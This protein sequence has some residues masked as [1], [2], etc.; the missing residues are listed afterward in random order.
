MYNNE[1]RNAGTV[2]ILAN[3][4]NRK[5][6]YSE[7]QLACCKFQNKTEDHVNINLIT[8]PKQNN[9]STVHHKG[10]VKEAFSHQRN[11]R[12]HCRPNISGPVVLPTSVRRSAS[13]RS[14]PSREVASSCRS[15]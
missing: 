10:A 8:Q 9:E 4:K 7:P 11:R 2:L 6:C 1:L 15:N 13:R 14:M 3:Y 12:T 5:K